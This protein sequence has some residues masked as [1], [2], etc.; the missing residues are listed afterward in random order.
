MALAPTPADRPSSTV[1]PAGQGLLK[2]RAG[3]RR[4]ELGGTQAP[5]APDVREE[6]L[7]LNRASQLCEAAASPHAAGLHGVT[8]LPVHSG[9][10]RRSPHASEHP[11]CR[12][13]LALAP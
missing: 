8:V 2:L 10:S 12:R 5:S 13:S 4:G 1:V 9:E 3:G 7:H 6:M 11:G